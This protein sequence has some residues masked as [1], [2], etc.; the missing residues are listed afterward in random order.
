M[1]DRIGQYM[2]NINP[3]RPLAR[4]VQITS[5]EFL[6]TFNSSQ[7]AS[8]WVGET[9]TRPETA[10][11]TLSLISVTPYELYAMPKATQT[12]ID[13]SAFDVDAFLNEEILKEFA[14]QEGAAF[15]TGD[16]IMKPR[17]FLDH[18][19]AAVSTDDA[20]RAFGKLLY[21]ATGV[22]GGP[23]ADSLLSV[24]YKLKAEYRSNAH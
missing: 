20:T 11:N 8:G 14:R 1:D 7:A 12:F 15:V 19:S 4:V 10:R 18:A 2:E 9:T 5:N 17:D 24:V 3:M 6:M 13:D 23:T 16:G 21:I 22:S